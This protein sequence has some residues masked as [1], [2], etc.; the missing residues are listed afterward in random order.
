MKA[1]WTEAALADLDEALAY[2]RRHFPQSVAP[3]ERRVRATVERIER[4]PESARRVE[5][6]PSV[7]VVPLIRYPY[8]IFYRIT[9][10]RIEILHVHHGARATWGT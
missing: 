2:T 1:V 8:R 7:R 3:F 4:W 6:R 5:E 10:D 9:A